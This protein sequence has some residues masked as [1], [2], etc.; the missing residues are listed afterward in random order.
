MNCENQEFVL[1]QVP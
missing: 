1:I